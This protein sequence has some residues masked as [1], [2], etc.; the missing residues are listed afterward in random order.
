MI[1]EEIIVKN[2]NNTDV[3]EKNTFVIDVANLF[4]IITNE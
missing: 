4:N 3:I 2:L 1:F